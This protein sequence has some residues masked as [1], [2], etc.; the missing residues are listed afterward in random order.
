MSQIASSA[1]SVCHKMHSR[2]VVCHMSVIRMGS[3]RSHGAATY[4]WEICRQG[5]ARQIWLLLAI[6]THVLPKIQQY[7]VL[8]KWPWRTGSAYSDEALAAQHWAPNQG[9]MQCC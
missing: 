2:M 8:I 1:L 4:Y 5:K 6:A 9:M 7:Y 3:S